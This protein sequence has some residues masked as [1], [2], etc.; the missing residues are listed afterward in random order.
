MSSPSSQQDGQYQQALA[1]VEHGLERFRHCSDEEKDLL[2][3]DLAQLREMAAKLTSGRI[4]IVVFGEISTGKSAL[5]NALVGEAV[6]QVDVQGGE[7]H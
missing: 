6:A 4:E 5:I 7:T 3:Q 1:S 2:R